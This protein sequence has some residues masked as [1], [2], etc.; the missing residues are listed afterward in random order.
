MPRT[1]WKRTTSE[2]PIVTVRRSEQLFGVVSDTIL[3]DDFHASDVGD[4]IGRGR[5]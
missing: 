3:E 4:A 2:L 1:V 5:L